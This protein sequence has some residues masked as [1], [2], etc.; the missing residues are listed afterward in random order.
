MP[1]VVVGMIQPHSILQNFALFIG[2][3]A[4]CCWEV[5]FVPVPPCVPFVGDYDFYICWRY[6]TICLARVVEKFLLHLPFGWVD[7]SHAYM[8]H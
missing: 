4:T 5:T 7:T 8:R 2:G 3:E 6:L 1:F